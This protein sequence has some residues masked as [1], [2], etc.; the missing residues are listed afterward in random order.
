LFDC[1]LV[2][3]E[4]VQG[5]IARLDGK[6]GKLVEGQGIASFN[7]VDRLSL[8]LRSIANCNLVTSVPLTW[9]KDLGVRYHC[10]PERLHLTVKQSTAVSD[11]HPQ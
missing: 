9:R 8:L 4:T 1:D 11:C 5:R 7:T 3:L 10:Q 2:E 6:A